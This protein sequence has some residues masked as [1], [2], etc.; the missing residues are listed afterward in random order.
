[1]VGRRPESGC[2]LSPCVSVIHRKNIVHD[3]LT[4][5]LHPVTMALLGT[6]LSGS[7]DPSNS[8]ANKRCF[9]CRCHPINPRHT[10]PNR[11]AF[12]VVQL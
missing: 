5:D 4:F 2:Q 12:S 3:W 6:G 8:G 11:L 1:M 7:W 10:K 9:V